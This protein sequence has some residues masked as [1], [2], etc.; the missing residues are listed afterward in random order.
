MGIAPAKGL[1]DQAELLEPGTGVAL[2][3]TGIQ[4]ERKRCWYHDSKSHPALDQQCCFREVL[5]AVLVQSSSGRCA[6]AECGLES[7]LK[8]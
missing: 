1:A 3:S 6:C 7:L 4:E 8:N 2:G 5:I